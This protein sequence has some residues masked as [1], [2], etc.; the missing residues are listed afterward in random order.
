MKDE[1]EI[2]NEEVVEAPAFQIREINPNEEVEPIAS[3]VN[4]EVVVEE[5]IAE[6]KET[7]AVVEEVKP[8]IDESSVLSYLKEKGFNA[9]SIE[10]LKPKEKIQLDAETEKY[11]EYKKETNRGYADFLE[12]QKDWS[13]EPKEN[14]LRHNLKMEN[15]TLTE[16]QIER[17]F[18]R[19]YE[20]DAEYDDED[21]ILDKQINIEKDYQKGLK[22]AESQKEKYMIRKGL[23]ES[24]PEEYKEA[25]VLVDNLKKQQGDY[26]LLVQE[27]KKDFVDKTEKVFNPSF[28]GFKFK[29][30]NEKVGF[31]EIVYKPDNII[32][33]KNWHSDMNNLNQKFFDQNGK[34][35][36]NDYY[37]IA[38]IARIGVDKFVN[39]VTNTA[40]ANKA[41]Q[42]D[43]LS[44][45]IPNAIRPVQQGSGQGGGISV[46]V[47]EQ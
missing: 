9:E 20:Y 15:P 33:A 10:D 43:K 1:E 26:E 3:I 18:K 31:D 41:I 35:I 46:R 16:A 36:N 47:I 11:L 29:T 30:G 12:T 23:D 2:V 25:K 42:D 6:V 24:V 27:A 7:P 39:H 28:E 22:L 21:V 38:E 32:E 40:L 4:E 17:L 44:K 45:N 14:I 8:T 34:V 13:A 37:T 5:P 19:E